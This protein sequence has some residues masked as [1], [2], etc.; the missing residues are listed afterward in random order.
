MERMS[1]VITLDE[2]ERR[3]T[4]VN[5]HVGGSQPM[6]AGGS[7]FVEQD[8]VV[9]IPNTAT[10]GIGASVLEEETFH[11]PQGEAFADQQLQQPSEG[12]VIGLAPPL[13][14]A[15]S[16]PV[17]QE[18]V[19]VRE[20][21]E[22]V[23]PP[24]I[25]GQDYA[26]EH[27]GQR[28]ELG[29]TGVAQRDPRR[30]DRHPDEL[31]SVTSED[32][33]S[34]GEEDSTDY[35]TEYDQEHEGGVVTEAFIRWIEHLRKET[36]VH[37]TGTLQ[38]PNNSTGEIK[39]A[40][41]NLRKLELK[42]SKCFVVGRVFEHAPFQFNEIEGHHV[43]NEEEKKTGAHLAREQEESG[44][45]KVSVRQELT[46]RTFD[47]RVSVGA[48]PLSSVIPGRLISPSFPTRRLRPTKPSSGLGLPFARSSGTIST[49]AVSSKS[50]RPSCKVA[51]LK[52]APASS[53]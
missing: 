19:P 45:G 34:E 3:N 33:S 1:A 9:L 51:L 14:V 29:E 16:V 8:Q 21:V 47:L 32:S 25:G 22:V 7:R 26:G 11:T 35:D 15:M 13:P 49:I 27:A 53:S 20:P 5:G 6:V 44:L 39:E 48:T 17:V 10:N 23:V 24:T 36:L 52:E 50:R 40:S 41:L 46:N 31:A 43:A 4:G 28:K 37:I 18:A 38:R 2:S 42:V 30:K 12:G